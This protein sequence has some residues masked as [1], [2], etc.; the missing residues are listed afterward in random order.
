MKIFAKKDRCCGHARCQVAGPDVF[1]LDDNG[2]IAFEEKDV[3]PELEEQAR[4]GVLA[5][6]EGI[7]RISTKD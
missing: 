4:K 6:P 3:P 7:L 1:E 5:C 2:Y